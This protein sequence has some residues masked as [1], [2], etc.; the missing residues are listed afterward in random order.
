VNGSARQ[1]IRVIALLLTISAY[2]AGARGA[3]QAHFLDNG[4]IRLGVDLDSGGSIFYFGESG[5]GR[6]LLNHHD[7]GR[8]IQQSYY[9]R[10]DGTRWAGKD[11]RWNPVQGGGTDGRPA[12]LDAFESDGASLTTETTPAHW[13]S[14]ELVEEVTLR[15]RITLR[16][17]LAHI[18]FSMRYEGETAHP[19]VHHE[20]PAVFADYALEHLVLYSGEEPWTGGNLQQTVPGWPNESRKATENWAAYVNGEGWGMGVYFPGSTRLTCYRFEGEAGPE[21]SGCSYFAP[22]RT[23]AIEPGFAFSYEVYLTIGTITQM[24]GRFDKLRQLRP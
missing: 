18:R 5:T 16:G 10:Q 6:N 15:A 12:R 2:P 17:N 13:A 4:V 23:M 8:F 19:P 22:I 7:R 20:L 3:A 14:G 21:G 11:W 24:R 9:G 1:A